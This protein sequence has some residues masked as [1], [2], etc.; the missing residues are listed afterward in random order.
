MK[1]R[2]LVF[3]YH[4]IRQRI[5]EALTYHF[6]RPGELS[7]AR[8]LRRFCIGTIDFELRLHEIHLNYHETGELPFAPELNVDIAAFEQFKEAADRYCLEVKR[9]EPWHIEDV[10]PIPTPPTCANGANRYAVG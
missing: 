4:Y 6:Q 10:L 5:D 1:E 9:R 2:E 8:L 3:I 7:V